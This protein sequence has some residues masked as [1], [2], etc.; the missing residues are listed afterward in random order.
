MSEQNSINPNQL[1]L[2]CGL[3]IREVIM[4]NSEPVY[5]IYEGNNQI[6][7]GSWAEVGAFILD[8]ARKRG[9]KF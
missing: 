3:E 9:I 2:S 8:E 1:A 4:M 7:S 6:F 5:V